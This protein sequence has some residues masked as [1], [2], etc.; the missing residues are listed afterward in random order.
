MTA[1]G[2]G[3]RDGVGGTGVGEDGNGYGVPG[4]GP[5]YGSRSA[6]AMTSCATAAPASRTTRQMIAISVKRRTA[7][8]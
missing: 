4:T 8:G 5:G 7:R 6:P 3:V 2:Y 1:A